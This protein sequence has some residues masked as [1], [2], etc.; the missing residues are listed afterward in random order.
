[1]SHE[2]NCI[3]GNMIIPPMWNVLFTFMKYNI[4][5]EYQQSRYKTWQKC[6]KWLV[7]QKH[8]SD[9]DLDLRPRTRGDLEILQN[10]TLANISDTIDSRIIETVPKGSVWQD[11]PKH[12]CNGDLYPR[13]KPQTQIRISENGIFAIFR[14]LLTVQSPP[15]LAC[16]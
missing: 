1:M 3:N 6:D 16:M 15:G 4:M 14:T 7:L 5:D 2:Y 12:V 13:S 9:D 8:D 10:Q 11:L